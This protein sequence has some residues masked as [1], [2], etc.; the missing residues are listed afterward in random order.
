MSGDPPIVP[1]VMKVLLTKHSRCL[2]LQRCPSPKQ[3][4]VSHDRLDVYTTEGY[5]SMGRDRSRND[6]Y[7]GAIKR[8]VEAGAGCARHASLIT[9]CRASK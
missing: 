1:P 6:I 2:G 4:L 8:A 9:P 3:N 5:G 7:R